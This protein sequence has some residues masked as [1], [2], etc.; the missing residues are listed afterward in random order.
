M[1]YRAIGLVRGKYVASEEQFTRGEL[2]TEDGA[3]LDAVLLGRVMSLVKKH[4]NLEDSHLWV[5]YPRTREDEENLH[6]QIVGVWEPEKLSRV[7]DIVTEDSHDHDAEVL[8]ESE[9][10]ES[11]E[12]DEVEAIDEVDEADEATETE[13]IDAVVEAVEANEATDTVTDTVVEEAEIPVKAPTAPKTEQPVAAHSDTTSSD[14]DDRYFSIRGE[15]VFQS[16]EQEKLLVKIRRAPQPGPKPSKAFKIALKGV[17]EGK[18]VGYFWDLNVERHGVDLMVRDGTM[19]GLVPPQKRKG[20]AGKGGPR[21]RGAG[22]PPRKPWKSREGGQQRPP[23]RS[24]GPP[25]EGRSENFQS[26][27]PRPPVSKPIKKRKE[28]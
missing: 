23:R 1:Q 27:G 6:V 2:L 17:L 5:V 12:I 19:I 16:I 20:G 21:R 9:D 25:R 22:G 28:D 24:D 4:V 11:D 8:D 18:A 14:L 7:D 10:D 3:A 26:S 15:I 13:E